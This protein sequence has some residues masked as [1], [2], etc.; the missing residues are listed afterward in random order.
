MFSCGNWAGALLARVE[1]NLPE[2]H[3]A[4]LQEQGDLALF[5]LEKEVLLDLKKKVKWGKIKQ[6]EYCEKYP[7]L[8]AGFFVAAESE[9]LSQQLCYWL[10]SLPSL[11][12]L[13]LQLALEQRGR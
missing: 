13:V 10:H 8:Q 6:I 5:P 12:I 7:S 11:L 9:F 4:Q 2:C 1:G 3:L